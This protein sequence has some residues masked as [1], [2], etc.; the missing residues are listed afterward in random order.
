MCNLEWLR[1]VPTFKIKVPIISR[2]WLS[3][4]LHEQGG[5]SGLAENIEMASMIVLFLVTC[6]VLLETALLFKYLFKWQSRSKKTMCRDLLS[7]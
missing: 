7:L 5:G 6:L 4:Y 3:V 2:F 1:P